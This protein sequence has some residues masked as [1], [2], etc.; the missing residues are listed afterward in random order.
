MA[1]SSTPL[2]AHKRDVF[3]T[4]FETLTPGPLLR[5]NHVASFIVN[6]DHGIV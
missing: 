1:L 4:F 6:A 3:V 5:L 2:K